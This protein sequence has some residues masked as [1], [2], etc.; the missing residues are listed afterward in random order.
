MKWSEFRDATVFNIGEGRSQFACCLS[1]RLPV[2]RRGARAYV[3]ESRTCFLRDGGRADARS[4]DLAL[5]NPSTMQD[6]IG[7]TLWAPRMAA[8][9]RRV[10][11]VG[12]VLAWWAST[13]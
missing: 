12:M 2:F 7:L 13:A 1:T 8:A 6:V 3:D 9:L 5:L 4:R 10:R 11:F